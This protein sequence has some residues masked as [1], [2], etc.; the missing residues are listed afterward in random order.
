MTRLRQKEP[1]YSCLENFFLFFFLASVLRLRQT[2]KQVVQCDFPFSHKP[3]S[4]ISPGRIVMSRRNWKQQLTIFFF[5]GGGGGE[6]DK[7]GAL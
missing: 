6:G 3:L 1:T 5:F 2:V 4:S 7:Q